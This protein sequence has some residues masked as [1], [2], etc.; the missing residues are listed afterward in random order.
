MGFFGGC[1]LDVLRWLLVVGE[2]V[3]GWVVFW[4]VVV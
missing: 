2:E 4:W 1:G 3:V